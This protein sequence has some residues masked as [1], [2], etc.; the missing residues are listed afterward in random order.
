MMTLDEIAA[1]MAPPPLKD[2]ELIRLAE[3][4]GYVIHK[5]APPIEPIELDLHRIRGH[6]VKLGIISD[7]HIGSKYQQVTYM[8]QHARFMA[9]EGCTAILMPGDVTDGSPSM[10]PGF[11]YETWAQGFDAQVTAA[12][13]AIPEVGI[14]YYV[15][16]GNHDA[17][18]YKAA[19]ADIAKAICDR[20]PD[21]TY[22]GPE[23]SGANFAGSV[24]WFNI[25]E[26]R[27]QMCHPHLGSTR[28]RSYRLETWIENLQPPRP[29]IVVMGNFHKLVQGLF[30]G[31]W[32]IMV[33]SY[34]SQS[35]WMASKG[36]ESMVG[37]AIIEFGTVTKGLAPELAVRWL[38][39]WEPRAN[40]WPGAR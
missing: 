27:L 23:Q 31:T 32:G 28:T 14:P 19:G 17:S 37:G 10:H 6:R 4:R 34:Q 16:G 24:G 1:Q 5:P 22:V 30:R 20:R 11:V 29:N 12:A 21:M 33:P 7:P 8:R 35:A 25:G 18:H 13:E 15:I 36:I 9:R 3:E 2:D 39:E 40:D 26:V 38:I